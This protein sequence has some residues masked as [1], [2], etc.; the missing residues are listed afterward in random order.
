M[1][2]C[3]TGGDVSQKGKKGKAHENEDSSVRLGKSPYLFA[4]LVPVATKC[5]GAGT[6]IDGLLRCSSYDR[7]HE[8]FGKGVGGQNRCDASDK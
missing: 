5:T 3:N 4:G 7:H 1:L 2:P 8:G 6:D